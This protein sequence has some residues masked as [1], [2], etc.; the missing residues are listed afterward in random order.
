MNNSIQPDALKLARLV[1]Y[2]APGEEGPWTI[3][4]PEDVPEWIKDDP[5]V[6]AR[7]VKGYV[8][9]NE[10]INSHFYFAKNL[11]YEHS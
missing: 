6:I 10:T 2:S 8:V 3:V 1:F 11:P 7:M 4:K 9:Q 5:D